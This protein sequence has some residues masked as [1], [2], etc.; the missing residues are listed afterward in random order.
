M[1]KICNPMEKI[2]KRYI[3]VPTKSAYLPQIFAWPPPRISEETYVGRISL[4]LGDSH[5]P[6]TTKCLNRNTRG[7]DL[8]TN[9]VSPM[10]GEISWI[11][12]LFQR[13]NVDPRLP[14]LGY[15]HSLKML[16]P[17][18][19]VFMRHSVSIKISSYRSHHC[20]H[21]SLLKFPRGLSE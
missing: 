3:F 20:P 16:L 1:E 2:C 17:W 7:G 21:H 10:C 19:R 4:Q 5:I 8:N 18:F 15:F 12:G 13:W 9:R 6:E 14:R 11:K